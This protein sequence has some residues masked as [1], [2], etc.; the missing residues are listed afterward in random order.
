VNAAKNT[1]NEKQIPDNVKHAIAVLRREGKSNYEIVR[2]CYGTGIHPLRFTLSGF[3]EEVSDFDILMQY[4]LD[5]QSE[6]FGD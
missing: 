4:L 2:M 5:S 3:I 6:Q 1:A